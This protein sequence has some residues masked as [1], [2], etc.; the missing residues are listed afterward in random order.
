M[1]GVRGT[2]ANGGMPF[3]K[4]SPSLSAIRL[5]L[6]GAWNI[7]RYGRD[8]LAHGSARYATLN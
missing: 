8:V 6:A 7:R 5:R 3:D 2:A 4:Y 1:A